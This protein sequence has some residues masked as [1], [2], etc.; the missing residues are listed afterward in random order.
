VRFLMVARA[1]ALASMLTVAGCPAPVRYQTPLVPPA[2]PEEMVEHALGNLAE[3]PFRFRWELRRHAGGALGQVEATFEGERVWPDLVHVRGAWRFGEEEEEEEA[4]GIGDQQY[5]SLGT[6]REWVRGPREEASNPLGQV[7]VVLG[8]GPFSFEGEEIHREKRMYVFGFEPNVALLD[9]TMT[10]SVTGQIW[11]DAERLLPERILA[12]EDGVASPSLWWEMAFDEIGG[13]L[14][15]RLPTAGR[16]HRIVLEPGAEER[17]QQQLLQAARTVVEARC[18]SF[19]PEA[20]IEVDVAGRRIVLDLG[21]VDAP[22]KVAQVA[23]RPGSLE[24]WLGCWPDEDV[25]TLRAEGVESRYGEGARL[26]FEREKVSRPLVLL[27]PLSGTPQGC[28]RAVRS[29]FDDLSRPLVEI[30]LDSLCAARLGEDGRLVDRPLAVVVDRRVVDAPIVRRGQLGI[31]RFGLGMSSDEVRGLV[32]I[33][34]SGPL[35]VALVVKEIT[36]R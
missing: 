29:A 26:A 2:P 33:L 25:V 21:N 20:D 31:I 14:E 24:L 35:P 32:A 18:R 28:M 9:P 34:E 7:E 22:F 4:Y 36:A 5:K 3:Q 12:R 13:P 6:E 10:K 16:R 17:P 27:R 19:A 1:C 30:E 15:L 11:V 8:K 23:V